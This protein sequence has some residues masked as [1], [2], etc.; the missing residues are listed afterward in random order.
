[1]GDVI[2]TIDI[3]G[4]D[5]LIDSIIEDTIVELV[6][7]SLTTISTTAF[8]ERR[9]LR[10]IVFPNVRD[11]LGYAFY[12]CELLNEV[13]AP[14]LESISTS[15]FEACTAL[16]TLEFPNLKSI[17]LSGVSGC[18]N[19]GAVNVPN[20]TS[21]SGSAFKKCT[22]L[23]RIVLPKVS[24]LPNNAFEDCSNLEYVDIP[25]VTSIGS[26]ALRNCTILKALI[27]RSNEI[28]YHGSNCLYNSGIV[29][30]VGYIYV[31]KAL[32]EDYKVA[33]NWSS[34]ST[35]F[36]ALEDYTVDGTITGELDSTKI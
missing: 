21:M 20:V 18:T 31:P 3:V 6:D 25:I 23:S 8:R 28:V 14:L 35:Q 34:Y 10:K 36:R 24:E 32:I 16:D 2:N 5:N 17:G 7:D 11:M 1:M 4:D 29:K 33:Q 9:N 30:K 19:L 22:S 15:C 26:Y 27:L 13:T 12:K